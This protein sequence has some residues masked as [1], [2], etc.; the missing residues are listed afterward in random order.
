[1]DPARMAWQARCSA[2][3]EDDQAVSTVK[4]GPVKLNWWLMRPL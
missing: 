2:T 3:S 4:T 1:M